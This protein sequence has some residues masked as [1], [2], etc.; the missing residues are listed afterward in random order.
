V[1]ANA[2][3]SRRQAPPTAYPSPVSRQAFRRHAPKVGA[4]CGNSACTDLGDLPRFLLIFHIFTQQPTLMC[5][6]TGGS[7]HVYLSTEHRN[8]GPSKKLHLW[9]SNTLR[10]AETPETKAVLLQVR[11]A[12]KDGE[13][14]PQA[15]LD[16]LA[17][18]CF[19]GSVVVPRKVRLEDFTAD[20]AGHVIRF[21]SAWTA[22]GSLAS[23][24]AVACSLL[25]S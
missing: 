12:L 16:A 17:Y 2:R 4:V 20:G 1:A 24:V 7:A 9:L 14:P 23:T 6:G 5:L 13:E 11:A 10:T 3:V 25:V 21:S 19:G 22:A 15:I 8:H 18:I